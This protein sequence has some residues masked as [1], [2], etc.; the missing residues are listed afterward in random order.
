MWL[1]KIVKFSIENRLTVMIIAF[2]VMGI[3]IYTANNMDVDVFP[4]LTA[5]TVTVMTESH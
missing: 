3:G 5:P 1:N 2:V 4:D